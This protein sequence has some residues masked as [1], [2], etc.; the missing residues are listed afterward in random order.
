MAIVVAL[1]LCACTMAWTRANTSPEQRHQDYAECEITAYGKYPE[2]VAH[3]ASD[4]VREPS[5][6][7]DT[8]ETLRNE[9]TNYCMRQRGYLFQRAN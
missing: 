7:V 6:D 4:N 2:N 5:K 1:L 8:N 9:E 3:I